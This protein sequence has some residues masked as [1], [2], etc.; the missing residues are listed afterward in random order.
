MKLLS[1][2]V[3]FTLL[4]AS[5]VRA[6][7]S[8]FPP[9][10]TP[11]SFSAQTVKI[12]NVVSKFDLS[13]MRAAN[14][15]ACLA[16]AVAGLYTSTWAFMAWSGATPALAAALATPVGQAAVAITGL[17]IAAYGLYCSF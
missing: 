1:L 11:A 12:D 3:T 8:S 2:I 9:K 5:S 17:G 16:G 10:Q 13:K 7:P 6:N 15:K 14:F 4:S